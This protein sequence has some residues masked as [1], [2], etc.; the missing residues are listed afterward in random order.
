M[1]QQD[2]FQKQMAHSLKQTVI[3]S[4][5]SMGGVLLDLMPIL[6]QGN[7]ELSFVAQKD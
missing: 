1:W 3:P 4:P 6:D 5:F 2:L 7:G